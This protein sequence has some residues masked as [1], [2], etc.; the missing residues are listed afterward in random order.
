RSRGARP[1]V[2]ALEER[3][4][5][6]TTW[7]V[8]NTIDNVN[9]VDSLRW[10]VANAQNGDTIEILTQNGA[11]LHIGLTHGELFLNHDVTIESVGPNDA[12]GA[13]TIDGEGSSRVFEVAR[14]HRVILRNLLITHGNAKAHNSLGNAALDG[15][16]GGIL[17]EGNL[18]LDHCD[19]LN[20][21][22]DDQ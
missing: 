5:L 17:N 2:E 21:A 3:C 4:L 20:N 13:A 10:A 15:D 7:Y 6:S 11:G 22:Y 14:G 8:T 9:Q 1:R 19:V 12:A 18:F 16:G